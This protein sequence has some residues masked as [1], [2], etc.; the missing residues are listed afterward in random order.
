MIESKGKSRD[1][2][3][4]EVIEGMQNNAAFVGFQSTD[5]TGSDHLGYG[6]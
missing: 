1:K 5:T 3:V 4:K 2:L 6:K